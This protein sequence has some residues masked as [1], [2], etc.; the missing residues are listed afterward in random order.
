MVHTV[1]KTLRNCSL[2]ISGSL[3]NTNHMS[4]TLPTLLYLP[5]NS[6][7]LNADSKSC[8][9]D[10][11]K[12]EGKHFII[13]SIIKVL[14]TED[15]KCMCARMCV[16]A[17]MCVCLSAAQKHSIEA[18]TENMKKTH[19]LQFNFAA[20]TQNSMYISYVSNQTSIFPLLF[21]ILMWIYIYN[22]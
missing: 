18:L 9:H 12:Y 5:H 3:L 17:L 4:F 20:I 7:L 22:I 14:L 11:L 13:L 8:F 16:H 19:F 6:H 10:S 1:R 21:Y 15:W 2:G